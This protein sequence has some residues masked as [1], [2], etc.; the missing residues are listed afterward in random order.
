MHKWEA[1]AVI[2]VWEARGARK[3]E[4]PGHR[5]LH[6]DGV[7]GEAQQLGPCGALAMDDLALRGKAADAIFDFGFERKFRRGR[8]HVLPFARQ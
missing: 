2:T 7:E 4:A 1:L 3:L 6:G 5:S 8:R